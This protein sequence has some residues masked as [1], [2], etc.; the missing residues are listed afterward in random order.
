M[1]KFAANQIDDQ[2]TNDT[3]GAD[4]PEGQVQDDSYTTGTQN[5]A[6]PVQGDDAPVED[7]IQASAADSDEQLAQ[8]DREA[9]DKSNIIGERTRGSKPMGSYQEPSDEQ[10]GLTE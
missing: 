6:I 4:V 5:E 10:M 9:I 3:L 8:D 2:D 7:P 1:S